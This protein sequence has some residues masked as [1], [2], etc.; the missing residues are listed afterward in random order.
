VGKHAAPEGAAPHP[1]VS[2]AM[3]ARPE[4]TPGAHSQDTSREGGL[5][6]PGSP[7]PEG[8]R[9]GWPA[10]LPAAGSQAGKASAERAQPRGW[11]RF[12]GSSRVA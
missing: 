5:G 11:R 3:A 4:R 6:W 8:G 2:G 12:F 9:V 7:P 1:L 10:D